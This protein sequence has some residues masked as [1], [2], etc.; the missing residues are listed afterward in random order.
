ML[1]HPDRPESLVYTRRP[2][3]PLKLVAL[4][5]RAASGRPP[6]PGNPI[7]RWHL[8]GGWVDASLPQPDGIT[9]PDERCPCGEV[10]HYGSTM[11]M[12]VWLTTNLS[13]AYAMHARRRSAAEQT[14]ARPERLEGGVRYVRQLLGRPHRALDAEQ[15]AD[16][17]AALEVAIRRGGDRSGAG[18]PP[19]AS[20]RARARG[21]I[22]DVAG[23]AAPR[24]PWRLHRMFPV[25]P[26]E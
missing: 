10:L 26:S 19:A 22:S 7:Y 18:L 2:N 17:Q 1:L 20:R 13:S 21:L 14:R 16:R 11:M 4:M 5:D 9:V 3:G 23:H 8:H 15:L 25:W 24:F 6:G 12:H